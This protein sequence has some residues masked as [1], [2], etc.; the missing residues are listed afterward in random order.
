MDI[1][2]L[3]AGANSQGVHVTF[4]DLFSTFVFLT[5]A[6]V[7]GQIFSRFLKM[8]S[9]VGEIIAG[10]LLGPPLA[11]FVPNP[12]GFVLF[13]EVGL[14]LLVLE[15]GID[16]DLTMLRLIGSRGFLIAIIGSLAPIAIGVGLAFAYGVDT[17]GA[18]AAGCSFGPTS[19]GIAMNILRAGKV[20]VEDEGN[21]DTSA[22]VRGL[23]WGAVRGEMGLSVDTIVRND[24]KLMFDE[25][26][27]ICNP[28]LD[29]PSP[30]RTIINTPFRL[31]FLLLP[32]G[33]YTS[34]AAC[35][36]R[37]CN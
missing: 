16:I 11:D 12:A 21:N 32:D 35:G 24:W 25:F 27:S 34:R 10:I 20:S 29:T 31:S 33:E 14:V 36:F 2:R 5:A 7:M 23:H 3:L 17:K 13:G 37:G 1:P 4:W 30:S 8:P 6:Y 28:P 9:L 15:A 22:P 18:I 26:P 19:L